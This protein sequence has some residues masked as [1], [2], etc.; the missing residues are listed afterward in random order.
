MALAAFSAWVY[1]GIDIKVLPVTVGL[2]LAGL[3]YYFG[4]SRSRLKSSAPEEQTGSTLHHDHSINSE[5][6]HLQ[7]PAARGTRF[8]EQI[9][10]TVLLLVMATL[11]WI[12]FIAYSQAS[13][14]QMVRPWELIGV[15]GLLL[16]ALGLVSLVALLHT[17]KLTR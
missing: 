13:D 3:A 8:L 6:D 16:L 7:R 5:N 4:W 12:V 9:T 1:I 11:G 15:T 10:S 17:R 14:R 2:Y